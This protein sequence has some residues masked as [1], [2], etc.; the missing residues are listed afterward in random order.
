MSAG[1]GIQPGVSG[2]SGRG[3]G[4]VAKR[5]GRGR[6]VGRLCSFTGPGAKLPVIP[7]PH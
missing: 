4:V 7:R 2:A 6:D 5:L 1:R 3:I